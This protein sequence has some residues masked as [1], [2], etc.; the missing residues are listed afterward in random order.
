[1]QMVTVNKT[2]VVVYCT[3]TTAAAATISGFC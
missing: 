2:K 3:K 1:M